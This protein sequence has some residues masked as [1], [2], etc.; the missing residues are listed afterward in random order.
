MSTPTPERLLAVAS[1]GT[2]DYIT[3]LRD[4]ARALNALHAMRDPAA[5]DYRCGT[6]RDSRGRPAPWPCRTYLDL[7]AALFPGSPTNAATAAA[8]QTL[9][10]ARNGDRRALAHVE[11]AV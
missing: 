8:W 7:H 4:T 11:A 6:C 1:Y 3:R 5:E 10:A 2:T 9:G